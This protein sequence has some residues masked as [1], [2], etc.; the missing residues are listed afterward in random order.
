MIPKPS[1]LTPK[2]YT[3]LLNI[4]YPEVVTQNSEPL[5]LNPES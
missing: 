4:L 2:S 5:T 1:T 3:L